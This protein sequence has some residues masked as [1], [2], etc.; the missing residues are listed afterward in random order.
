VRWPRKG[1]AGRDMWAGGGARGKDGFL[2]ALGV[3]VLCAQ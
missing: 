3:Q 1:L 2:K